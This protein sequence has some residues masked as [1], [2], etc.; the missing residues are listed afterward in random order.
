MTWSVFLLLL[1]LVYC[2][3]LRNILTCG[4]CILKWMTWDHMFYVQWLFSLNCLL[5]QHIMLFR[6]YMSWSRCNRFA[7][8]LIICRFSRRD[9][10][11]PQ[12]DVCVVL[13]RPSPEWHVRRLTSSLLR[14][15]CVSFDFGPPR[16]DVW[17][18]WLNVI[19][20]SPKGDVA[21]WKFTEAK[22]E[23]LGRILCKI[24]KNK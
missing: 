9:F 8:L 24:K 22:F 5:H 13:L 23:N 14:M 10:V 19:A 6:F 2:C 18:I 20:R 16:N 11:P 17:V 4:S 15:T 12:N 3:I 21:I 1:P 7:W